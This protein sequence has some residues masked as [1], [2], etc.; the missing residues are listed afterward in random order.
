MPLSDMDDNDGFVVIYRKIINSQVWQNAELFQVF[1][2]C[3][4]KANHEDNWVPVKT[5]KGKTAVLIKRGQFMFGRKSAAK[6][7]RMKPSS[8]R[9]RM[10]KLQNMRNLDI[11][12]DTHYSIVTICNYNDYQNIKTNKGQT[13]GQP[14]DNQRTTKG[15]PKDTNNNDNN[16]NNV[17][18]DNNKERARTQ[19]DKFIKPSPLEVSEYAESIGWL[20]MDGE[21]FVNFYESKGWVIGKSPMKSWKSAVS[22]WKKNE[23]KNGIHGR[24]ATVGGKKQV[25]PGSQEYWAN[26]AKK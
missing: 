18:N 16:D 6:E 13:V 1:M 12:A 23:A 22:N 11:K 2:W 4:L 26:V 3:I 21:Y 19:T 5:G 17:N 15:Q 9:N 7:L 14:K 25:D 24:A 20:N 10:K 8:V